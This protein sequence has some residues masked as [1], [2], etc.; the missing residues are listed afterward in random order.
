MSKIIKTSRR[1]FLAATSALTAAAA[2]GLARPAFAQQYPS[3]DIHFICAFPAGSG[4]DLIVR[5]FADKIRPVAGKNIIV[6]NRVGAGG[7][8]AIEYIAR[9]KPDGHTVLL[10]GGNAIAGMMSL[11]KT[12]PVDTAKTIQLAATINRQAFMFVVDSKSPYKTIDELTKGML[13]KGD[14]ASYATNTV[15]ATVMGEIYKAKTGVKAVEVAYKTAT[16]TV[17][18]MLSGSIDF[19]VHN[20]IFALAQH[21]EG[22]M[23]VLGVGSNE[24][25]QAVPDLP[26]MTEQGIPMN[27]IGWWSASVPSATPKETVNTINKWFVDAV[28]SPEAKTFLNNGGG[29]PLI[30]TPDQAQAMMLKD[31]EN[32]R[33]YVKLAKITPQG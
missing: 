28:G 7:N 6:E 13:A 21:K 22:K 25:L 31:T 1:E 12:P 29:D 15:D 4:A 3:Q 8:L 27:V 26:T 11:L 19:A 9:A 5:F 18:D 24:R 32:W 14:K 17:N 30:T 23:R 33:E 16:D 2:T 10:H 20:P